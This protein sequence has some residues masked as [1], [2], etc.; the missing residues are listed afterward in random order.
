[1][2][3]LRD[4]ADLYRRAK[5]PEQAARTWLRCVQ[6]APKDVEARLGLVSAL[7]ELG[8][9]DEAARAAKAAHELD[10]ANGAASLAFAQVGLRAGDEALRAEAG[11]SAATLLAGGALKGW[12]LE[13]QLALADWQGAHGQADAALASLNAAAAMDSTSSSV[14]FQQGL[15]ELRAGRTAEAAERFARATVL[16]P[17]SSAAHLNLGIARFQGAHV[18]GIAIKL[19]GK[20]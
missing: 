18:A 7:R 14:P 12:L 5:R 10:P 8:R 9:T 15:L 13:D 4:L 6:V 19:S 17:S 11:A 3:A 2:P 20:A 1:M 16:D